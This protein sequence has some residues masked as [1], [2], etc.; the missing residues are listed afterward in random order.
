MARG[1]KE[2]ANTQLARTNQAAED[3]GNWG[4]QLMQPYQQQS[5]QMYGLAQPT[6]QQMLQRPGYS[7]ASKSNMRNETLG[8]VASAHDAAARS[9]MDRGTRTG[10]AA[11]YNDL[12]AELAR[13][14]G[15]EMGQATGALDL[16]FENEA[17][18]QRETGLNAAS[19]LYGISNDALAKIYGIRSGTKA[20][21][22]GLGPQTL[23]ARAAGRGWTDAFKNVT[24]GLGDLASLGNPKKMFW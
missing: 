14:K 6:V 11:G 5:S 9:A 8:G 2:A 23:G 16:Q 1:Q 4:T 3:E 7:D 12:A 21:L 24:S 22:Y 13:G 15:R 20:D 17:Q 19:G 10:N 18:R